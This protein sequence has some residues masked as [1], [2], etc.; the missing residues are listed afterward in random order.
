[1]EHKAISHPAGTTANSPSDFSVIMNYV[2]GAYAESSSLL[3]WKTP[4]LSMPTYLHYA[5]DL[6]G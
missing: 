6:G 4:R 5:F 2:N 3:P 1:M